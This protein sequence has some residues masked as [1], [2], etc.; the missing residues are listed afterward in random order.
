M[1]KRYRCEPGADKNAMKNLS[2]LLR[3]P[4]AV[5]QMVFSFLTLPEH[6]KLASSAPYLRQCSSMSRKA[7]S[8]PTNSTAWRK[9]VKLPFKMDNN[10]LEKFCWVAKGVKSLVFHPYGSPR[11]TTLTALGHLS[12]LESVSVSGYSASH[13]LDV[14]GILPQ[15][16]H[17]VITGCS[18]DHDDDLAPMP[19]DRAYPNLQTVTIADS[20]NLNVSD[21]LRRTPNLRKLSLS[22][23]VSIDLSTIDLAAL[24]LTSLTLNHHDLRDNNFGLIGSIHTLTHLDL[25]CCVLP[26]KM[27]FLAELDK[28]K[29]LNLSCCDQTIDLRDLLPPE[30]PLQCPLVY[31]DLS[32][33]NITDY[34]VL[35]N[36]RNLRGLHLGFCAIANVEPL[37]LLPYLE[38]INLTNTTIKSV[39]ALTQSPRLKILDIS[40]CHVATDSLYFNSGLTIIK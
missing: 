37:G 39:E 2:V 38:Y 33:T 25:C 32:A 3:L 23:C 4:V 6:S 35:G 19:A 8:L 14:V 10:S 5:L 11:I 20:A 34:A 22:N 27:A 31:L 13:V 7:G 21:V 1:P 12:T 28:L 24:P 30:R 16:Q 9:E 26:G 15:L 36:M 40:G 29:T 18:Y 17:V